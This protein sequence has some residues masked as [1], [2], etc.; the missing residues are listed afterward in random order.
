MRI[1][2]KDKKI[3]ALIFGDIQKEGTHPLTDKQYALQILALNH[4][5][6]AV[7]VPHFH[8]PL[9]RRTGRLMESVFVVSGLVQADIYYKKKKMKRV[10][11][12][13]G[14]G[15]LMVNGGIGIKI[16]KNA[17]MLEFKNGP[18][19]EDKELI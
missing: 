10:K 6:G 9:Q 7:L 18:F 5:K 16:L 19:I 15:I 11:L 17:R 13:A 14:R 1:I 4:P 2:K 12:S 8:R 3:I